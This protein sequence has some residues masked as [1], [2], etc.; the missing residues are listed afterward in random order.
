MPAN[1]AQ[2]QTDARRQRHRNQR[3]RHRDAAARYHA[4][5]DIPAQ[6]IGAERV[7]ERRR[8]ELVADRQFQ[9]IRGRQEIAEH[10]GKQNRDDDDQSGDTQRPA[11]QQL[12]TTAYASQPFIEDRSR[13]RLTS[14]SECADRAAH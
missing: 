1:Y 4:R 6:K 12:E 9:R 3:R 7:R 11:T 5:E 14:A 8:Q 2:H 10:R 13:Q